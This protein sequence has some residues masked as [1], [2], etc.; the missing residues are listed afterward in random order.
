MTGDRDRPVRVGMVSPYSLTIPGGVQGQV[1]SLARA[2]RAR[3]ARVRVLGPCDG[4]PPDPWVT[5]LG[6]SVPTAANGSVA[7]IAPD[8]P[9]AL[10]TIRS[11]GDENFDVLHL[12]EP[13]VP[14]PT[15]TALFVKPAPLVGTFHA[16]GVSAAYATLRP[17][18]RW[19]GNRLDVRC[20]VSADAR[21]L[22]GRFLGG[23]FVELFNG[24]DLTRFEGVD[25][26]PT[27]RPTIFF[28]GRHEPR[29]GLAVVLEALSAL[30]PDVRLWVASDGPDTETLKQRS[31]GD[32]R[33]EWLGRISEQEKAAR[34]L[35]A[36]VF[37]APSLHGESF[38]V[39]LL[40]SMAA[41]TPVVASNLPGYAAVANDGRDALLVEPGDPGALAKGLTR[42]PSDRDLAAEL[43]AHGTDRAAELSMDRL[44]ERYLELYRSVAAGPPD[45]GR[46]V[47]P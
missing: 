25:P 12:H 39:V 22:A 2:V 40:E 14:G 5:P 31:A 4:P 35:G 41:G 16:A 21:E 32:T 6:K 47:S 46:T 3:G 10:R 20:V 36:D 9:A 13:L 43:V 7:P 42:V 18:V 27:D 44:A 8:L 19:A 17:G 1:L 37:C 11:L 38:G 15:M 23:D 29:K 45:A 33:V 30:P 34:L 26:W 24:V 28:I